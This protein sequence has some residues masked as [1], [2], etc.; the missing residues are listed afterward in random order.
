[1]LFEVPGLH[2]CSFPLFRNMSRCELEKPGGLLG[3]VHGHDGLRDSMDLR[4][5]A[6]LAVLILLA[7]G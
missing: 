3:G 2:P 1:M 5:L 6:A 4:V 7:Q